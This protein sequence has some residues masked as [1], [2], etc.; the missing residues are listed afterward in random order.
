MDE[1]KLHYVLGHDVRQHLGLALSLLAPAWWAAAGNFSH[2]RG[3]IRALAVFNLCSCVALVAVGWLPTDRLSPWHPLVHLVQLLAWV[4]L[5]RT[6]AGLTRARDAAALQ[7]LIVGVAALSLLTGFIQG[8]TIE[9][10]L[11]VS[12][13]AQALLLLCGALQVGRQL[14]KLGLRRQALLLGLGAG[15]MFGLL[16]LRAAGAWRLGADVDRVY[17]LSLWTGYA[18]LPTALIVNMTLA[19]HMFGDLVR[20]VDRLSRPLA[21]AAGAALGIVEQVLLSEMAALRAGGHTLIVA[22]LVADDLPQ[23]PASASAGPRARRDAEIE[24]L[25]RR[26]LGPRDLLGRTEDGV[27]VM[28]LVDGTDGHAHALLV[29]LREAAQDTPDAARPV[30]L[31]H[32]QVLPEDDLVAA[33]HVARARCRADR[34]ISAPAGGSA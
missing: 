12:C 20:A 27:F 17:L 24:R 26:Q 21:D 19:G 29:A 13:A 32:V 4:A 22:A 34:M 23:P 14:L 31:G 25:L 11:A 1:F 16:S 33:V 28:A 3:A 5:W 7:G 10:L 9:A 15:L 2:A 18:A 6:G 8:G 30:G